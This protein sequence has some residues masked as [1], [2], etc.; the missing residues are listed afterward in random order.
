[1]LG[2]A[3]HICAAAPGGPRFDEG[4]SEAERR[5]AKNGIW[6]CRL[7]GTS[8]D[9]HDPKFTVELLRDWKKRAEEYSHRS[10]LYNDTARPAKVSD[11]ELAQRLQAAAAAD[12][13][14]FHRSEK[15]PSTDVA[16]TV[17]MAELDKPVQTSVLAR[18]L[19]EL[20]DLVLVAP[21]GMGKTSTLLQVAEAL[22]AHGETPIFVPLADW[23]TENKTVLNSI[24]SRATFRGKV[25]EDDFRAVAQEHRRLSAA[26][27]LERT[28]QRGAAARDR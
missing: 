24:L 17:Q 11:G 6:M 22:A 19:S 4:M 15:W 25:S 26:R 27:R 20:G 14:V 18:A 3:S 5:S 13:E 7:H 2:E 10:V 9:S 23:A 16:L 21:P 1:M 8:V 28:R 12:V